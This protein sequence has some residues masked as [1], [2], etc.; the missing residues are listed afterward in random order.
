MIL[1]TSVSL[2]ATE[3]RSDTSQAALIG[4]SGAVYT[5]SELANWSGRHIEWVSPEWDVFVVDDELGLV[6]YRGSHRPHGTTLVD[7]STF[8]NP[9]LGCLDRYPHCGPG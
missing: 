2:S 6:S 1:S 4:L 3:T 8:L 9:D 5:P 7:D